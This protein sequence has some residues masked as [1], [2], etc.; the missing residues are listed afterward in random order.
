MK[1]VVGMIGKQVA[2]IF[3]RIKTIGRDKKYRE[4]VGVELVTEYR[5]LR[6]EVL[7]GKIS[8]AE[9]TRRLKSIRRRFDNATSDTK[10]E[11]FCEIGENDLLKQPAQEAIN[12]KLQE[13]NV[14]L[15]KVREELEEAKSERDKHYKAWQEANEKITL[16]SQSEQTHLLNRKQFM[17]TWT[18]SRM[19]EFFLFPTSDTFSKERAEY[20]Q[21]LPGFDEWS[22][23]KSKIAKEDKRKAEQTQRER[24]KE[25]EYKKQFTQKALRILD[26]RE[27]L[28]EGLKNNYNH[29]NLPVNVLADFLMRQHEKQV[30]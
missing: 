8:D 25:I 28:P 15:R 7:S 21:G 3:D 9:Y 29:L 18:P 24:K 13:L 4:K 10:W 17:K 16:L 11:E 12:I 20:L 6:M 23:N 2:N 5:Q 1:E 14:P 30:N 22:A 26:G 19:V 27:P